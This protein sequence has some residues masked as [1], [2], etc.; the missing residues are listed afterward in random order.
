MN[1][2]ENSFMIRE[3]EGKYNLELSKKRKNT[4]FTGCVDFFYEIGLEIDEIKN[5]VTSNFG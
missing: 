3:F 1:N 4:S 5:I 2:K